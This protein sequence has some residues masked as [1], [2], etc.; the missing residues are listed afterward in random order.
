M[1][2]PVKVRRLAL[3]TKSALTLALCLG[4]PSLGLAA[5]ADT[6]A[7]PSVE[8]DIGNT[9]PVAPASD[10]TANSEDDGST[11]ADILL[12]PVEEFIAPPVDYE[13][14]YH[15]EIILFAN[16]NPAGSNEMVTAEQHFYPSNLVSIGPEDDEQRVPLNLEQQAHLVD[17]QLWF[18]SDQTVVLPE[19]WEFGD[20]LSDSVDDRSD[21]AAENNYHNDYQNDYQNAL[22]SPEDQTPEIAPH[23]EDEALSQQPAV[24]SE[25]IDLTDSLTEP[26]GALPLP[27]TPPPTFDIALLQQELANR[28]P[29]AFTE[30]GKET[31]NLDGIARS[32]RR[33]SGYRLLRH[34]AWRQPMTDEADALPVMMQLGEE[35]DGKFEIEGTLSFYRSRYLHVTTDLWFTR[36][37]VADESLPLIDQANIEEL[38][39]KPTPTT[40]SVPL[41]H[42]RR[43]RSATL[44]FIDHPQFGMLIKID[45]YDGPQEEV[46]IAE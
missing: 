6:I 4:L 19:A 7:G 1:P 15:V 34:L 9:S 32:I 37:L 8:S 36:R 22:T 21:E 43:M 3:P 5:T 40:V 23:T 28:G 11:E 14:W 24:D 44:H 27:T 17:D 2:S 31:R 25:D 18:D 38:L 42:S 41:R 16:L 45:R 46:E 12:L 33:S 29:R 13:P 26:L 10:F 30:L 35:L 39:D 20:I